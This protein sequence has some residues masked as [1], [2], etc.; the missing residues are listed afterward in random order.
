MDLSTWREGVSQAIVN[1]DEL[2][3]N[4]DLLLENNSPA[5]AFF[6]FFHCIRRISSRIFYTRTI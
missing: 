2:I 1:I 3:K 4:G 5:H 6:L